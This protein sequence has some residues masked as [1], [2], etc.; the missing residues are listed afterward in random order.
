MRKQHSPGKLS[1]QVA[2]FKSVMRG[3]RECPRCLGLVCLSGFLP[4]GPL[5]L[6]L[7]ENRDPFNI[8]K[9]AEAQS[10]KKGAD[11]KHTEA[12][13]GAKPQLRWSLSRRRWKG[14]DKSHLMS[15]LL[16]EVL[17]RLL[18]EHALHWPQAQAS[19]LHVRRTHKYTQLFKG[20]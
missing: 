9:K 2:H 4:Q 20:H 12:P 10:V 5:L 11:Q 17:V 14:P 6:W 8:T 15:S 1:I 7:T 18:R 19:T 13:D 16:R 3:R